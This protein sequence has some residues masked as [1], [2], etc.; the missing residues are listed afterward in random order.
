[1][2]L[3]AQTIQQIHS[4]NTRRDHKHD[5]KAAIE[6]MLPLPCHSGR[7]KCRDPTANVAGHSPE[8]STQ[9]GPQ[10]G[11]PKRR[12][13]PRGSRRGG[14]CIRRDEDA[15]NSARSRGDPAAPT[16][17][18][19]PELSTAWSRQQYH[20]A[21]AAGRRRR[22]VNGRRPLAAQCMRLRPSALKQGPDRTRH[23]TTK[24][25]AVACWGPP[26]CKPFPLGTCL[27]PAPTRIS[28]VVSLRSKP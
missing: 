2:R 25:P 16:C 28:S 4:K 19:C 20:S 24:R 18:G 15:A 7:T 22:H 6:L 8:K 13:T 3:L 12:S 5:R 23:K 14:V 21:S 1:M 10:G 11:A 27:L 17:S 26:A 9:R